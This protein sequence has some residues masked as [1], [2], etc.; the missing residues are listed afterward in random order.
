[1]QKR[2]KRRPLFWAI[3][4]PQFLVMTLMTL[5][6]TASFPIGG[7]GERI[8]RNYRNVVALQTANQVDYLENYMADNWSQLS[9]LSLS[10]T[11]ILQTELDDGSISIAQLDTDRS[12]YESLLLSLSDKLL[13]TVSSNHVSGAFVILNTDDLDTVTGPVEKP[14]LYLRDLDPGSVYPANEDLL[15]LRATDRVCRSLNLNKAESYQQSFAFDDPVS[16]AFFYETFQRAYLASCSG[17]SEIAVPYW[18]QQPYT[19]AGDESTAMAYCIPLVLADGT[20]VG[21]VGVELL[22]DQIHYFL[23]SGQLLES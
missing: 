3:L 8:T 6:L 22:L 16:Q 15:V 7:M 23:P 5:V 11:Q 10:A 9:A 19:M 2:T 12:C 13:S 17:S 20:V 1:M 14:C 4:M 21:V 18:T